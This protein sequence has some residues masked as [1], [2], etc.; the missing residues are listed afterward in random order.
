MH[1]DITQQP[2]VLRD[3][4]SYY[5]GGEGAARLA[6]LPAQAAPLFTGMGASLHAA[7][8]AA[9]HLHNLDVAALA[10]EA[11]DLVFYSRA[12]LRSDGP[13]VFVSQSGASAE[14]AAVVAEL[15]A[16]RALVAVTNSPDSPLA[17]RAQ[18]VL[19]ILAGV[20]SG[21]ATKTYLN[22]L[23]TLW[24]LARHW[25]GGD[26]AD[27]RTLKHL[28]DACENL[29]ANAEAVAARW[30]DTLGTA[31]IIVFL[32]HGPHAATARQASMMLAER[33]RVASIGTSAGAFRHG[34]IEITQ[35]G[36]GAVVFVAAG[37]AGE[38]ARALAAEMRQH[39]A[40]VLL[41]EQGRT[42]DLDE[43]IGAVAEFDEF[44]APILD[45]LPVQLFADALAR[46]RGVEP[47]FRYIG[48]VVTRL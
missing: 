41:V 47:K 14:V 11:T 18:F 34:P 43:P 1:S 30:L 22:T 15:P 3:L 20:E 32:G 35:P 39:G 12:L 10:V 48:K 9:L 23:A 16:A 38:S 26:S 8:V 40:R 33:A 19:P 44:L 29:I 37:P 25:N 17:Q 4:A 31:E 21:V 45:I 7:Q 42:R 27:A 13:L 24:L 5:Q 28:A 46:E 2:Q 6:A 36:I